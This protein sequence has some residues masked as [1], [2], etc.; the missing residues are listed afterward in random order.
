MIFN[1]VGSHKELRALLADYRQQVAPG[2]HFFIG[3]YDKGDLSGIREVHIASRDMTRHV[4]PA[5]I[6]GFLEKSA[7][8]PQGP[9]T[10]AMFAHHVSATSPEF[11]KKLRHHLQQR[12][13][14]E[15]VRSQTER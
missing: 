5:V 4:D 15:R 13:F 2:A 12:V 11:Q 1:E 8:E 10:N 9:L 7:E 6:F 14:E 3:E